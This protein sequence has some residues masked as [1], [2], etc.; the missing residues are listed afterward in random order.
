MKASKQGIEI[1][2]A[3]L[4]ALLFFAGKNDQAVVKF[5]VGAGAKLVVGASDG[6][7]AVECEA[8]AADAERGEWLVPASYLE[9]LR[10]G[11]NK[12]RT[13]VLL[14][15]TVKGLKD[16]VLRGAISRDEHQEVLDKTNGTSTQVSMESLHKLVKDV[17]LTGSWFAIVPKHVNKALDVISKAA[18]G[19]PI[20]LYPPREPTE[21]VLFEASGDGGR[22]RGKLQPAAVVAPGDEA[23]EEE[24]AD[25]DNQPELPMGAGKRGWPKRPSGEGAGVTSSPGKPDVVHEAKSS[26]GK[27]DDDGI[28]DDDYDADSELPTQKKRKGASKPRKRKAK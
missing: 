14:R 4:G 25:D 7:R 18:D 8:N 1:N 22:W 10:R 24:T 17:Q 11:V 13:E 15:V 9:L 5:R 21:H 28:V 23:E 3:E 6:K 16:A 2:K 26:K 27:G 19:C 12:G 20:T